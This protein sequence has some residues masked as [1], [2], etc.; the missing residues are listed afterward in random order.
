MQSN[1]VAL[2]HNLKLQVIEDVT[3]ENFHFAKLPM[4]ITQLCVA[5]TRFSL[6]AVRIFAEVSVGWQGFCHFF[7]LCSFSSSFLAF[8]MLQSLILLSKPLFPWLS[9]F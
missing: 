1:Q 2:L 8:S 5:I 4:F 6:M 3:Q 7:R 9:L